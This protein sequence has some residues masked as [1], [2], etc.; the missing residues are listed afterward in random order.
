[1]T[2]FATVPGAWRSSSPRG[3]VTSTMPRFYVSFHAIMTTLGA[4]LVIGNFVFRGNT[5]IIVVLG[6][7][8]G[9]SILTGTLALRGRTGVIAMLGTS[10]ASALRDL[11][12]H[13]PGRLTSF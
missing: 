4:V 10:A 7:V 9:V 8:P 3:L 13:P 1:M 12:V 6:T 11:Q 5:V 2:P